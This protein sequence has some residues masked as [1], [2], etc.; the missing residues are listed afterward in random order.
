MEEGVGSGEEGRGERRETEEQHWLHS[1]EM[2][3]GQLSVRS[4]NEAHLSAWLASRPVL[5]APA[6]ALPV[7]CRVL[8]TLCLAC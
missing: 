2:A 6:P 5:I 1:K 3:A 4:R 7:S 8:S